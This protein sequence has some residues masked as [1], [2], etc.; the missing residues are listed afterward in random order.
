MTLNHDNFLL[1]QKCWSSIL[2]KF[3]LAKKKERT[4]EERSSRF[5]VLTMRSFLINF[6]AFLKNK[7]IF[8]CKFFLECRFHFDCR[9]FLDCRSFLD[10][11]FFFDCKFLL[12]CKFA[13]CKYFCVEDFLQSFFVLYANVKIV[14]E[15]ENIRL[16]E[17]TLLNNEFEE[18]CLLFEKIVCA[19]KRV[20][21][22]EYRIRCLNV[23]IKTFR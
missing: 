18:L 16:I 9:F 22:I 13:D 15:N 7:K 19:E 10:C 11:K 8:D 17:K 14:V 2:E 3:I 1:S 12:N 4:F 6:R 5:F 23:V 20:I 21:N